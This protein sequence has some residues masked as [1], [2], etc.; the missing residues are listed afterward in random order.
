MKENHTSPGAVHTA[1]PTLYG[2]LVVKQEADVLVGKIRLMQG[3]HL[4]KLR[5]GKKL[6]G[7]GQEIGRT[8]AGHGPVFQMREFIGVNGSGYV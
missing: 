3:C 5:T 1:V 4:I 2:I 6:P 8:G 7:P